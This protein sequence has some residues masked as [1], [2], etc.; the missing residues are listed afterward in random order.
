MGTE[1][2]RTHYRVTLG[3]TPRFDNLLVDR[4]TKRT[5][6]S[7]RT[8]SPGKEFYW[9]VAAI[10]RSGTRYNSEGRQSFKTDS[11]A[12]VSGI[13]F[14]SDMPCV[15]AV[16]YGPVRRDEDLYGGVLFIAGKPY[17]KGLW[18]HSY[19]DERP[20][21]I[22]FDISG[23]EFAWFKADVGLATKSAGGSLQFQVLV[24]G[25][26]KAE[27]PVLRTG[28]VYR[29]LEVE[30]KGSKEVCLRVLNGGDGYISDHAAWGFARFVETGARDILQD[31]QQRQPIDDG[32]RSL[33][34]AAD[35]WQL[36]DDLKVR[37]AYETAV[38][39]IKNNRPDDEE[40]LR[41]RAA[42]AELLGIAENA[43]VIEEQTEKA[44]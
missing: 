20:A 32:L 9:R 11:L 14:A 13:E 24:D 34:L 29:S 17:P 15:K 23:K 31:Y 16:G 44:K 37:N 18:I 25:K 38:E 43:P 40:L 8:L 5:V 3:D 21:D 19:Q 6:L 27:T 39:W 22:V 35:Y 4:T 2:E 26:L 12:S 28:F 10:S 7:I 36:G 1:W 42:A 33:Y 41:F 30:V